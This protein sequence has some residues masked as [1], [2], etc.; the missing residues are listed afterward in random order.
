MSQTPL[1][2]RRFIRA[3]NH[4][5]D[6]TQDQIHVLVVQALDMLASYS[7]SESPDLVSELRSAKDYLRALERSL[8]PIHA[9]DAK[10]AFI[11]AAEAIRRVKMANSKDRY[12]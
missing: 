7:R 1:F 2:I 10:R 3:A 6:L 11:H 8:H 9:A 12:D 5:D 4:I